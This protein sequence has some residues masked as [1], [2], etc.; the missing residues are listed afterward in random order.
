M[1][2]QDVDGHRSD[3]AAVLDW[4]IAAALSDTNATALFAE[5]CERLT[6]TDLPL[7]R[8]HLAMR[9]LH[10]LVDS[11]DL[12]WWRGEGLEV[13]SRPHVA[14]PVEVWLQSPLYW[15]LQ[16]KRTEYRQR[17][18]DSD[19]L[20]RFPVFRE[21]AARGARRDGLYCRAHALRRLGQRFRAPGR[22][23][24]IVGYRCHRRIFRPRSGGVETRLATYRSGCEARQARTSRA[25]RRRSLSGRRRGR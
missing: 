15:M 2:T 21:F 20:E 14:T 6:A 9:T 10:P 19:A 23:S 17:L 8:A 13:M 7:Q 16:H 1:S 4:L 24:H 18:N 25:K 5:M 3:L 22:H 11:V 12:T